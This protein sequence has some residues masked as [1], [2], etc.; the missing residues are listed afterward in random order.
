MNYTLHNKELP[1]PSFFQVY[2]FG[3]GFGDKSRE[4]VYAELTSDTP[5]LVNYFYINNE[6][7]YQFHSNLFDKA[8]DFNSVGDLYNHV[9]DSLIKSGEI[10]SGYKSKTYD[11]NSKVFLLDSGA[12]NIVKQVACDINYD[13]DK[14]K[15]ELIKELRNYYD[16]ADKLKFDIVVGFD[17]GGKYTEKDGNN[18]VE[19][20]KFLSQIDTDEINDFLTEETFKY[21]SQKKNFYPYV[22]ATVHGATQNDYADCV[23]NILCLE[24]KY[25]HKFWGFAL[26][27]LGVVV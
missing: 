11:F 24:S 14:L 7:N 22:L 16:F 3:G 10:Y 2:N 13:V 1:I 19:I 26:G 20:K 17:L 6:Y 5:A 4:I 21:L 23:K 18:D 8:S 9:R 27:V 15:S 25:K 12:A